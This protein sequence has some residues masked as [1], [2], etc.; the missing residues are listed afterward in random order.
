M[1]GGGVVKAFLTVELQCKLQLKDLSILEK[2]AGIDHKGVRG[3]WSNGSTCFYQDILKQY[4]KSR[5]CL[6][7]LGWSHVRLKLHGLG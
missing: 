5:S 6:K 4:S 2:V 7:A 1:G 3:E